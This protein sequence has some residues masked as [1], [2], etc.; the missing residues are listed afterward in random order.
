MNVY[1]RGLNHAQGRFTAALANSSQAKTRNGNKASLADVNK[2]ITE[3]KNFIT[4]KGKDYNF[5]VLRTENDS[6]KVGKHVARYGWNVYDVTK[7]SSV[8]TSAKTLFTSLTDPQHN[9]PSQKN[10]TNLIIMAIV[11]GLLLF[12]KK[13][14][15]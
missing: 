14:F 11:G 6:Y 10:N 4:S 15:K 12:G 13:I 9:Q 7:K 5:K 3:L 2:A 1:E 8:I